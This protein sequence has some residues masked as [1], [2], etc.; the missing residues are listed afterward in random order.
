M[1]HLAASSVGAKSPASVDRIVRIS[2]ASRRWMR[3]NRKYETENDMKMI[4]L[5]LLA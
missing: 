2:A 4:A 3:L 1:A 5:A